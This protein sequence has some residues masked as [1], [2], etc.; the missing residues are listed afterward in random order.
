MRKR[1]VDAFPYLLLLPAVLLMLAVN[2][3]PIAQGFYMSLLKLNQFTLAQYL[4]LQEVQ[5]SMIRCYRGYLH[6]RLNLA[7]LLCPPHVL[8]LHLRVL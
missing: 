4:D 1:K 6:E 3:T 7:L 2:L 5:S 8:I